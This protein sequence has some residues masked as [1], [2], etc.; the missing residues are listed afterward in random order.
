VVDLL[1]SAGGGVRVVMT[2]EPMHDNDWTQRLIAGRNN[3]LDNLAKVL[4]G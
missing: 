2:V 1:A 3:E 4:A